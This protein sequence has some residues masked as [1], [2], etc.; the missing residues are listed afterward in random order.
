MRNTTRLIPLTLLAAAAVLS[1]CRRAQPPVVE[2]E[3]VAVADDSAERARLA[4]EEEARRRAD[5][6]RRAEEAARAERERMI[7]ET[8]TRLTAPI[9]F[10]YDSE[11]ID[12]QSRQRLDDKVAI[13]Q[14]N[15]GL[16]IR[17]AGH[18][19]ERGSDEYNM[20]LGQR[21]AASSK[22]YMVQQGIAD[23]RIETVSFGE[24]RPA[25]MGSDESAWSQNRRSEFE[26][27]AG[28]DAMTA[29]PQR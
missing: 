10:A 13:L 4:A 5:D 6:A 18:T 11:A 21:R 19:D 1:G 23:N 16:R 9:Y 3:P 12:D 8:R 26:I 2:P 14:A 27:I 22:R 28:G 29:V 20:A 7:A 25:A 15:P 24:E 17:V